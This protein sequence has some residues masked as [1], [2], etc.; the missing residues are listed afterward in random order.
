ML[1]A[2][3][4]IPKPASKLAPKPDFL[5]PACTGARLPDGQFQRCALQ[6]GLGRLSTAV[7]NQRGR[8]N[9]GHLGIL[10][11]GLRER[12]RGLFLS[13]LRG[14]EKTP[15]FSVVRAGDFL[16]SDLLSQG[17]RAAGGDGVGPSTLVQA[18]PVAWSKSGEWVPKT[19]PLS[20]L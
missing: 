2:R 15:K 9:G 13:V 4:V 3:C 17:M 14:D 10:A 18:N 8:R 19:S 7:R 16:S 1:S 6:G 11:T 5:R 12:R 20:T